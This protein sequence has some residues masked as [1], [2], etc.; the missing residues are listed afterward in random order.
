MALLADQL[1]QASDEKLQRMRQSQIATAEANYTRRIQELETAMEKADI[2]AEP[3][4]YGVIELLVR[5]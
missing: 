3:V 1:V 4:A 5:D 2:I